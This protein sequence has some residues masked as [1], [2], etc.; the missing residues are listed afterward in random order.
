MH[1]I[2]F[3]VPAEMAQWH[4]QP[5]PPIIAPVE[6]GAQQVIVRPVPT[7]RWGYFGAKSNVQCSK[8]R[9]YFGDRCDWIIRLGP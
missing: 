4:R 9:G 6:V 5:V 1:G 8:H 3:W 7:F 2:G